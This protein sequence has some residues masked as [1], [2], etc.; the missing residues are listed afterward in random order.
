MKTYQEQFCESSRMPGRLCKCPIECGSIS[1]KPPFRI[2][3]ANIWSEFDLYAE[4]S[5]D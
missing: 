3:L 2:S 5:I 1:R 4:S